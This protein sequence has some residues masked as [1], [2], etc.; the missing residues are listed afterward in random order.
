MWYSSFTIQADGIFILQNITITQPDDWHVHVRDGQVLADTV[1]ASARHFGRALVMPNLT[2]AVSSLPALLAYRE[3]IMAALVPDAD[4]NPL[5]TFYLNTSLSADDLQQSRSYDF[6]MG[7]KLYPAGATTNSA[8]GVRSLCSI[9]PLLD[10]MRDCDLV[11]Q[12]HGETT[13]GDIF[14]REAAFITE[15]LQDIVKN[16]PGLRIVLEHISTRAAVDFVRNSPDTVA[17]TITPHHLFYNRNQLLAGGVRPHYYCLPILKRA[18]DQK[19]LRE[20]ACSGNPKFFAGTDSAPH[21]RGSKESACG[22]AGVYCAPYAMPFYAQ[23]FEQEQQL[24]RLNDFCSH[25]GAGFYRVPVNRSELT[26]VKREHRIPQE[27]AFGDEQ[28][29]PMAAGELLSWSVDES[30]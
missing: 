22:C 17:A 18:E 30:I 29:V 10:V 2:P 19:A 6:V 1:N 14:D 26:L 16:F 24:P 27:L 8:E 7:A 5:M 11:L 12:V 15:H 13:V 4:F 9:Y 25:F 3:R 20:A 23:V 21:A 28:V